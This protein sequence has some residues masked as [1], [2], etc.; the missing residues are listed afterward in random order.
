MIKASIKT[1]L[2]AAAVVTASAAQAD[3][4]VN[5]VSWG[6]AYTASPRKGYDM[7]RVV[8]RLADENSV[9]ELKPHYDR[10]LMTAL[11]R[12]DGHVV[13]IPANCSSR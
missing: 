9:L 4:S 8:R 3:V 11:A 6:G 7:R 2:L 10:S 13:G 5:V 1:T 12:L